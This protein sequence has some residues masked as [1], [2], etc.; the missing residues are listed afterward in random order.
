[1]TVHIAGRV[2]VVGAIAL[3]TQLQVERLPEAG[4][5]VPATRIMRGMGGRGANQAV[6]VARS[7]VDARLVASVG[8]DPAGELVRQEL[9][10]FG[11]DIELVAVHPGEETG[12]GYTFFPQDRSVRTIVVAG[13]N[14]H[15][16]TAAIDEIADR[17]ASA[18]VVLVQGEIGRATIE[19]TLRLAADWPGRVIL[20]P[21]PL[22]DIDRDLL[23]HVD[24]L[25]LNGREAALWCGEEPTRDLSDI[26]DMAV[27]LSGLGPSVVVSVG[28]EGAV[29]AP[30]GLPVEFLL[31]SSTEVVD[32]A[33]ASDALVGVLAAG[34]ARG[35]GVQEAAEAAVREATRTVS[36]QGAV[37]SYPTFDWS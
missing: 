29:V 6:A 13:A 17:L 32:R 1:M 24:V 2:D 23:R 21:S 12:S 14:V 4:E 10:G 34:I 37:R 3:D 25:V 22:V 7:G 27:R 5:M 33:G 28:S 30:P 15:T 9:A 20:S 26:E 31:A 8:D 11:V 36:R 16:N 18:A 35:L 19:Q